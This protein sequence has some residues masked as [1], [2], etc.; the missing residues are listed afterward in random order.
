VM[1]RAISAG[2]V[3]YRGALSPAE[4]E[5]FFRDIDVFLFPSRYKNELAP[6]VV[7]ESLLRGVPVITYG[8]GCLS[9]DAVG[10]GSVLVGL[11]EDFIRVG[12]GRLEEWKVSPETLNQARVDSIVRATSERRQAID[13]VMRMGAGLF[14]EGA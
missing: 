6:A 1:Q 2:L 5:I 14:A 13:D 9:E 7:W 12:L 3:E 10:P 4:K 8:V 11:N